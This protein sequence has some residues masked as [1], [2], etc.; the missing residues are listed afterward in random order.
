MVGLDLSISGLRLYYYIY[1]MGLGSHDLIFDLEGC[2]C[3]V[4][5]TSPMNDDVAHT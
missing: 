1:S 5:R 4:Q 2:V 3:A